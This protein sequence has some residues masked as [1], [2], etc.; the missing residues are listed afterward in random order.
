MLRLLLQMPQP[1]KTLY[2]AFFA[3]FFAGFLTVVVA[4]AP[5]WIAFV[6]APAG[7]LLAF[8]GLV[9]A[10]DYRDNASRYSSLLKASRPW[11]VDYCGSFM[12]SPRFIRALGGCLVAIGLFWIFVPLLE[13]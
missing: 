10:A 9:L 1:L 2:A 3:A 12:S 8:S 7:A 11:G 13:R 5:S 4:D 6:L